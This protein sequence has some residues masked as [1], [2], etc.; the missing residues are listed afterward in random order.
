MW[1]NPNSLKLIYDKS[2]TYKSNFTSQKLNKQHW[3][4][5]IFSFTVNHFWETQEV[6]S[7]TWNFQ[8]QES[9]AWTQEAYRPPRSKCS[10]CC[11]VSQ[12]EWGGIPSSPGWGGGVKKISCLNWH[13][14]NLNG[15]FTS[16]MYYTFEVSRLS[17]MVSLSKDTVRTSRLRV[18]TSFPSPSQLPTK[19]N[20]MSMVTVS[21]T[22]QM[23][24]SNC[25]S[26]LAQC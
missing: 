26:P 23:G 21:L 8:P 5:N 22:G 17:M 7:L 13:S 11:S 3:R 16:H 25:P 19:L 2:T 1:M 12:R 14:S 9:P 10:L 24:A 6:I 20:V 4:R 15:S 18:P